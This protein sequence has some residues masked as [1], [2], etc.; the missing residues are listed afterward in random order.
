M[1]EVIYNHVKCRDVRGQFGQQIIAD[2]PKDRVSEALPFIYWGVDLF[3]PF[4]VKKRQS[5]MKIYGALFTCLG[6]TAVN[7]E[8]VASMKTD[9]FIMKLRRVSTNKANMT[10]RNDNGSNF[11]GT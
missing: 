10:I 11:I 6:S 2:L 7:I 3:Q 4:L 9:S 8:V 5:E 1:Q